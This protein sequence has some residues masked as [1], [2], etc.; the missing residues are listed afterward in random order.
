LV[1]SQPMAKKAG[2]K[3]FKKV[4]MKSSTRK[5]KAKLKAQKG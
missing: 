2:P 3:L 5:I 1:Y 4:R